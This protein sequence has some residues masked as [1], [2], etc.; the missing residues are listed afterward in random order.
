MLG[1]WRNKVWRTH[2]LLEED[3]PSSPG[4]MSVSEQGAAAC[5]GRPMAQGLAG[6]VQGLVLPVLKVC[7][8]G[9]QSHLQKLGLGDL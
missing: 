4:G 2:T 6:Q 5:P 3:F 7:R 8:Q 1:G 9:G